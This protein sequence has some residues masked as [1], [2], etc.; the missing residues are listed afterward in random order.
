MTRR[1]TTITLPDGPALVYVGSW[2][3]DGTRQVTPVDRTAVADPRERALY[4][5]L[6]ARADHL[7]DQADTD[8]AIGVPRP[9]GFTLTADTQ[10]TGD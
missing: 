4:R 5:G 6:T 9:V 3:P 2:Q 1:R 7:A 10:R 8:D